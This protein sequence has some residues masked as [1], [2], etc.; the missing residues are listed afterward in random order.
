MRIWCCTDHETHWPVGGAS[1]V[2][3]ETEA[4]AR[5]L[6]TE[7]LAREGL[8]QLPDEMTLREIDT[9]TAHAVVLANGDY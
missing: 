7:A 1:I 3:A 6:L 9:S 4:D 5:R 8:K 2:V